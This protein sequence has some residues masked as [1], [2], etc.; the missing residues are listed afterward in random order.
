MELAVDD[1]L[2]I[3]KPSSHFH[4][5]IVGHIGL[6]DG[7]VGSIIQLFGHPLVGH[8]LVSDKPNDRVA[9]VMR[10]VVQEL[11]LL[12]TV[13]LQALRSSDL[14]ALTPKPLETPVIT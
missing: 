5:V 12:V 3:Q 6:Q 7:D 2:P 9:C 8:R 1:S 4:S 14:V 11:P 13:R 10:K